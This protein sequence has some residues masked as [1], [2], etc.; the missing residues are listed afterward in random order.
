MSELLH[1]RITNVLNSIQLN[2][3][4]GKVPE[5]KSEGVKKCVVWRG[6]GQLVLVCQRP[7]ASHPPGLLSERQRGLPAPRWLHALWLFTA[8]VTSVRITKLL[9]SEL[10]S[11]H[12]L[13][14][15]IV[16]PSTELHKK[17]CFQ[18]SWMGKRHHIVYKSESIPSAFTR[19]MWPF[20]C[21]VMTFNAEETMSNT[22][23][24]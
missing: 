16:Y 22:W 6:Q 3:L 4:Y 21:H 18:A 10:C 9:L 2:I 15:H 23:T 14:L 13:L 1:V 17:T 8:A 24:D 19:S 7:G 20:D 11:V 12:V 5:K